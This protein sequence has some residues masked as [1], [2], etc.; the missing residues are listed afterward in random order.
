MSWFG[1]AS[2]LDFEADCELDWPLERR[3]ASL[4]STGLSLG[5]SLAPHALCRRPA[6]CFKLDRLGTVAC[7]PWSRLGRRGAVGVPV[8][9]AGRWELRRWDDCEADLTTEGS[10]GSS[11]GCL[12]SHRFSLPGSQGKLRSFLAV[13]ALG[14]RAL[15]AAS[16]ESSFCA[17]KLSRAGR[18]AAL[19]GRAG[20]SG[21]DILQ[22]SKRILS[23]NRPQKIMT[24]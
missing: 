9:C 18:F 24:S 15:Y 5:R 7:A 23:P 13:P 10:A 6:A 21:A 17:A 3:R 12:S 22:P 20:V 2:M 11:K 19:L 4:L 1:F 16:H 8:R 14:G